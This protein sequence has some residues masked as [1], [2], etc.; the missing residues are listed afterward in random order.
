MSTRRTHSIREI[1]QPNTG[2]EVYDTWFG[3]ELSGAPE[4]QVQGAHAT[5]GFFSVQ[6]DSAGVEFVGDGGVYDSDQWF[7]EAGYHVHARQAVG[8]NGFSIVVT[9]EYETP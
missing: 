9:M 5:G 6:G 2:T 1:V 4:G 7:G 8:N 3:V